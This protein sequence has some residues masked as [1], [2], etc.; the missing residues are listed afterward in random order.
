MTWMIWKSITWMIWKSITWM[1]WKSITW[2]IWK[3]IRLI[4]EL[5]TLISIKLILVGISFRVSIVG[6]FTCSLLKNLVFV[7]VL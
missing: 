5:I 2:M 4:W 7:V 3:S 6:Q 1:I